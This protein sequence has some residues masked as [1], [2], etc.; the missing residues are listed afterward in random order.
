MPAAFDL[1]DE[2][3]VFEDIEKKLIHRAIEKASGNKGKAVKLLGINRR[4][5]CSILERLG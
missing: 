2:G 5:L 1:P 3:I 4:E